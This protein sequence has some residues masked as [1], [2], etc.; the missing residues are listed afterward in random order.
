LV[1]EHA[2]AAGEGGVVEVGGED[3]GMGRVLELGQLAREGRAP[4]EEEAFV[5]GANELAARETALAGDL[6]EGAGAVAEG[7]CG[8][9]ARVEGAG[10]AVGRG[11]AGVGQAMVGEE[12]GIWAAALEAADEAS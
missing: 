11:D 10:V 9:E 5:V 6:R 3:D 12:D 8:S 1:A 2:A 7:E 4:E